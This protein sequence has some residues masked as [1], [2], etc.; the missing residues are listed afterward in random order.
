MIY[1]YRFRSNLTGPEPKFKIVV[2]V[3]LVNS[4]PEDESA[5]PDIEN[6]FQCK[7]QYGLKIWS[8]KQAFLAF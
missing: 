4:L 8:L 7:Q 2:I 6:G 5:D 1:S 3:I